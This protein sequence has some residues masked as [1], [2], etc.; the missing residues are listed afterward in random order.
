LNTKTNFPALLFQLLLIFALSAAAFAQGAKPSETAAAKFENFQLD[1]KLMARRMPYRVVFPKNYDK[2]KDRRYPV[3]Y[4]LHGLGGK[5]DNWTDKTRLAE[6][7]ADF[8]FLIVTPEGEN[9]W[10]TDN[11]AKP[12]A[13]YE[14]YI[15][16]ELIPE[17][18][19][20]FRTLPARENR[21][22]G[23][24]SM[25]GFGALKFG[26]KHPEKFVLAGSFSGAVAASSYRKVEEIP[27][28]FLRNALVGTFGEP[29][30]ETHRANN[31]FKIIG[32][33]PPEK[34]QSLPFLYLDCGTEDE[35]MLLPLN[36]AFADLLVQ[37]K[38]PHEY[39][40]LPGKHNWAYWNAQV[41]EF[42][43]LADKFVK[44][45]K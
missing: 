1:S 34:I 8:D 4:L 42:L 9:G 37:R 30:G 31:L 45:K 22:V 24:L 26:I 44:T 27:A 21:V 35:L 36:R 2:A 10:Y 20:K 13:R 33:M 18:D 32:E 12:N 16:E 7:A 25:G 6:Y 3:V 41:L 29:E 19:K 11:P 43:Q 5:F 15:V 28:G 38:I 23:G 40:Q 14:S 17:I 39:R